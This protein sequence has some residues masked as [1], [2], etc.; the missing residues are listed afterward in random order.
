[1]YLQDFL[2]AYTANEFRMFCLLTKYRSG[3]FNYTLANM[4]PSLQIV[5]MRN[6]ILSIN[7]KFHI[8]FRLNLIGQYWKIIKYIYS[9]FVVEYFCISILC[10]FILPLHYIS[11]GNIVLSTPLPLLLKLRTIIIMMINTVPTCH[12]I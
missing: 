3:K 5:Q 1:M 9:N 2:Q 4:K 7:A 6:T 11:E 10:Y 12:S 8:Q